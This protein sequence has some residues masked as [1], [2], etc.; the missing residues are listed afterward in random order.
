M[1]G[2]EECERSIAQ[3]ALLPSKR[4][5]EAYLC[6]TLGETYVP[7]RAHT[8]QAIHIMCFVHRSIANLCSVV[9][10]A[11]VACG[12]GNTLGNKGAVS[13][14]LKICGT[15]ILVVNA[16]LSAHQHA[17]RK[18]NAEFRKISLQMPLLLEQKDGGTTST[19]EGSSTIDQRP[20]APSDQTTESPQIINEGHV[21]M[22]SVKDAAPDDDAA[23]MPTPLM[24]PE[25]ESNMDEDDEAEAD[26]DGLETS[27]PLPGNGRPLS[28][29]NSFLSGGNTQSGG[30]SVGKTIDKFADV[31]IFMGDLNY[32]IKGNRYKIAHISSFFSACV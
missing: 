8:L 32:R 26:P 9:T 2:T 30:A 20:T 25:P 11:A 14:F 1:F 19:S 6:E 21:P 15:K 22:Q 12:A 13:V 7:L 24:V 16:H 17:E 18:R 23:G 27:S 4:N 31:V 10:S 28:T 5:W 29:N 3:S